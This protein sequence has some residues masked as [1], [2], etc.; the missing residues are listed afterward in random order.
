MRS[1]NKDMDKKRHEL[2]MYIK[3][4]GELALMGK[5][6][7]ELEEDEKKTKRILDKCYKDFKKVMENFENICYYLKKYKNWDFE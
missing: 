3:Q 4:M 6:Y 7:E 5:K 1:Y 2:A